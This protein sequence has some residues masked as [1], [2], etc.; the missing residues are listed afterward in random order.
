MITRPGASLLIDAAAAAVTAVPAAA[1]VAAVTAVTVVT[2]VGGGRS[3][4]SGRGGG[5]KRVEIHIT[6]MRSSSV[7]LLLL[8]CGGPRRSTSDGSSGI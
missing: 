1:A 4:R 8:T 2:A 3:G 5:G 7:A 6:F